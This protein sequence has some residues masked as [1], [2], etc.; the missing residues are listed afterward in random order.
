MSLIFFFLFALAL[1]G[2]YIGIRRELAAPLVTALGGLLAAIVTMILYLL[3]R[4]TSP[5]QSVV[6]G[7]LIGGIIGGATLAIAWY[8]QSSEIRARY[9]ATEQ[10]YA[11]ENLAPTDEYYE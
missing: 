11:A 8:F 5:L 7:A 6:M 9:Y 1:L 3:A 4:G 2:S 10:G